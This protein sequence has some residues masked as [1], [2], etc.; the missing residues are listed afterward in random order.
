MAGVQITL[1]GSNE[2]LFGLAIVAGLLAIA[3]PTKILDIPGLLAAAILGIIVGVLGHWTYLLLLLS[4]LVSGHFVT[5][6]KFNQKMELGLAE[7]YDGHRSWP[8]VLA[9]GGVPGMLALFAFFLDDRTMLWPAL[10]AAIAVAAADTFASEVGCI[11]KRVWMIT[12]LRRTE[13]GVNGGFSLTG[14]VAAALGSGIVIGIA[15]LLS[16]LE[17]GTLGDRNLWL[18]LMGIGWIGCQIDSLL[19][20]L[21]E[22]RGWLDKNSVNLASITAGAVLALVWVNR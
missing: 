6:F 4:F 9:N 19:G 10:T 18:V 21:L 17:S 3:G 16:F 1:S 2:V 8:N 5:R 15:A 13:A 12:T 11:D 20:A 14:Q 7:S 22:N